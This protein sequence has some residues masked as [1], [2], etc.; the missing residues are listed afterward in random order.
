MCNQFISDGRSLCA[1]RPCSL[2]VSIDFYIL[3]HINKDDF[4][5]IKKFENEN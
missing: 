1:F 5:K 3:C 2:P 4:R